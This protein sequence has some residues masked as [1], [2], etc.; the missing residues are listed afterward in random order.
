IVIRIG[1][2]NDHR[3]EFEEPV[4]EG[5][6]LENTPVGTRVMQV[7]AVDGDIDLDRN[8]NMIYRIWSSIHPS[9]QDLFRITSDGVIYTQ[10]NLDRE[11]Q[12]EHIFIIE[13]DDQGSP[14]S[15][16]SY[17]RV[18]ITI[19]DVNEH[20]PRFTASRY[21]GHVTVGVADESV[22]PDDMA[23]TSIVTVRASDQDMGENARILY[24]IGNDDGRWRINSATGEVFSA[25]RLTADSSQPALLTVQASDIG[26]PALSSSQ[27]AQVI[28]NILQTD[29][30]PPKFSK[31]HYNSILYTPTGNGAIVSQEVSAHYTDSS[32]QHNITYSITGGNIGSA[33]SINPKTGVVTVNRTI[34]T[35]GNLDFEQRT[36]YR[37]QVRARD[38]ASRAY[39]D[40]QVLIQVVDIN[41]NDPI[42]I[43]TSYTKS[44]PENTRVGTEVVK[45][46]AV[47]LDSGSFG[48]ISYSIIQSPT[49]DGGQFLID[50]DTGVIWTASNLDA[51]TQQIMEFV[52]R[53]TDGGSPAKYSDVTVTLSVEDVNDNPPEFEKV[54]Y[55]FYISAEASY[56]SFIGKVTAI[57]PDSSETNL[58]YSIRQSENARGKFVSLSHMGVSIILKPLDREEQGHYDLTI[59]ATDG[60]HSATS[61][62]SVEIGD[63]NDNTPKCSQLWYEGR[64]S[65][66]APTHTLLL[67][68]VS[69][70]AD[71]SEAGRISYQLS[72]TGSN[73]FNL[74]PRT[75]NK[76][77]CTISILHLIY[78]ILCK[79][80]TGT[81]INLAIIN[82]Y[83]NII[84]I[85]TS[86][87]I[88]D[89]AERMSSTATLHLQI[90]DVNDNPPIFDQNQYVNICVK[91]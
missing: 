61:V 60:L 34:T 83:N 23:S 36:N 51:E 25:R 77:Y 80:D 10:G 33:F 39:S 64:V 19:G 87:A 41:D 82:F 4:Y 81:L 35:L 58:V 7:T 48:A 15:L 76:T 5:T 42:F 44:L 20:P 56:Q 90:L 88:D 28:I 26:N 2:L 85:M 49:S 22:G 17:C 30:A 50:F 91:Q 66:D 46:H 3:P 86:Q 12:K 16:Q 1:D 57:D 53:A 13:V 73:Q 27:N 14:S 72:G 65:E 11:V 79:W 40:V 45:V 24:F 8:G 37:L 68:V 43:Q 67:R 9:S 59:I 75:E 89:G 70:D 78:C 74:D 32:V 52:V 21:S 62:V 6:V 31:P 47:D 63:I 84:I 18:V 69:T 38:A 71:I 54:N 29:E 55:E